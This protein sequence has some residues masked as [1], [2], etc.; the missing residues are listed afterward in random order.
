MLEFMKP[1][2]CLLLEL[3]KRSFR[4]CVLGLFK[5]DPEGRESDVR[6]GRRWK[7]KVAEA[8][9]SVLLTRRCGRL[10][11]LFA[12]FGPLLPIRRGSA[13]GASSLLMLAPMYSSTQKDSKQSHRKKN[14][15]GMAR[16]LGFLLDD[17]RM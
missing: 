5:I 1:S 16:P 11:G 4:F 9:A 17:S 10:N 15:P 14:S 8:R 6:V 12:L 3:L 7:D 2:S 13:L